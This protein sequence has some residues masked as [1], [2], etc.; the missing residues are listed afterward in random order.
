[1][2]IAKLGDVIE[3]WCEVGYPYLSEKERASV[4]ACFSELFKKKSLG[5][6]QATADLQFLDSKFSKPKLSDFDLKGHFERLIGAC[7]GLNEQQTHLFAEKLDISNVYAAVPMERLCDER[8]FCPSVSDETAAVYQERVEGIIKRFTE[9][10]GQPNEML[11]ELLKDNPVVFHFEERNG[12]DASMS[13]IYLNGKR[14]PLMTIEKGMMDKTQVSEDLL[15]TTVAHE[16]GHWIDMA[17][18]P[19][20][21]MGKDRYWQEYFADVTGY[22]VAKNAGYDAQVMITEKEQF[23]KKHREWATAKGVKLPEKTIFEERVEL[24][25]N[26]FGKEGGDCNLAMFA[27]HSA[28][29]SR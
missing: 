17:N 24:L 3:K 2:D 21:Y 4:G 23:S 6:E 28:K 16:L 5:D 18:R 12:Q 22:Q 26:M 25:R 13:E 7:G 10:K 11:A 9:A 20:D 8:L 29:K 1:M 27:M 15:A 14:C 19:A